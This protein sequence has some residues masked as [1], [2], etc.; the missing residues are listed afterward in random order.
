MTRNGGAAEANIP[1]DQYAF[2]VQDD[3][4]VTSRVTVNFGL[5]Y[6][7]ID[8]IQ[9]DQSLNPNF[10]KV[11]AAG[12]AGLLAGIKG[13][14]NVGQDPKED[15]NNWQ[16]RIGVAWDVRGDGKDVIR[17]GWGVYQDVGYTNANVLFPA[18]DATGIGSGVVFNVDDQ[19]GIRNPDGSFYRVGQPISN[20]A[21]QNQ[22][23][24]NALPLIGQWLDPRLEMPYTRQAAFGWSHQLATN[25]VFTRRLR[26]QRRA[27]P[28][29]A[30]APQHAA[31]RES[32][33]RRAAWP[34]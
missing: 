25:M 29:H 30:A 21:S 22:A 4:R 33:V 20:I 13:M 27:R 19:D 15:S 26:P 16:P 9:V 28:E 31:G 18:I 12:R 10:V 23:N 34:S 7:F 1:L 2:Y 24:P 11:Q 3:W 5:R 32:D 17:A 14:E 6:D 8:G